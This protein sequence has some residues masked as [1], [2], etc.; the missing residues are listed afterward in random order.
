MPLGSEG[1]G[2]VW[3][4][5]GGDRSNQGQWMPAGHIRRLRRPLW[6]ELAAGH[7]LPALLRHFGSA[8]VG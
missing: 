8:G 7:K 4:A 2:I 1:L 5:P 6:H 3:I